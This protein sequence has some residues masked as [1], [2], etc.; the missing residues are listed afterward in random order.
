MHGKLENFKRLDPAYPGI[1]LPAGSK[2]DEEVWNRFSGDLHGLRREAESIRRLVETAE[3]LDVSVLA[4]DEDEEFPEGKL[5]QRV[6]S[7]RE[8]NARLVKRKKEQALARYGCLMCEVCG[9]N[10]EATY[11]EPGHGFIECHH[12]IPVTEWPEGE[13]TT[14]LEDAALVCSNCHRMLHRKRPWLSIANLRAMMNP[15]GPRTTHQAVEQ[16]GGR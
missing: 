4:V 7:G 14:R 12:L 6:H 8:R 2:Q 10:F 15:S 9:F 16:T 3:R 13:K 5:A 1:G 11:G